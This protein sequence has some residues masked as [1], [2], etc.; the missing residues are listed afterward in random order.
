MYDVTIDEKDIQL[1]S[2]NQIQKAVKAALKKTQTWLSRESIRSI[3]V[4][5]K[6]RRAPLSKRVK[7]S[8]VKGNGASVWFGIMPI[9]VDSLRPFFQNG[10]GV[11]SGNDLY[12]HAFAQRVNNSPLLVWERWVERKKVDRRK[13]RNPN[14]QRVHER[15]RRYKSK[16]RRVLEP[17]DTEAKM[18]LDKLEVD[19]LQFF[20]RTLSDELFKQRQ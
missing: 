8:R 5:M 11:V 4:R 19:A 14:G 15:D 7:K 10:Q 3:G 18:I 6:I 9:P 17:I 16:I 12:P 20:K 2:V 1:L 13:K